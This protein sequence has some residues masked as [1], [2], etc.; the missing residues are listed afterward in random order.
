MDVCTALATC[1]G[2]ARWT[3]LR[4][5]GVSERTLRTGLAS[6]LVTTAGAGGYMLPGTDPALVAAIRLRGVASHASAAR[7]HGLEL[8]RPV[9]GIDVTVRPGSR[10]AGAGVRVHRADL[11]PDE[12]D[13]RLPITSVLRTALDCGRSLPLPDAVVILDSAM[14]GGAVKA[15][16]L[17]VAAEAA[18]GHGAV[19][20]R[21]AVDHADALAGS[22]LESALR[23]LLALVDADVRSQVKIPG[24]GPGPVDFVLDGWLVIEA[25]GFEFHSDRTAY[26]TDRARGN[27][28]AARG[29]TLLRFTWEDVRLRPGWV[30]AQVVRTLRTGP[31]AGDHRGDS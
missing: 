19:A 3:R 18:R 14:R 1:G 21:R 15:A 6:G 22:P 23:L 13:V 7:L 10:P 29:Y 9:S 20:L 11:H 30:L 8:W 28:L 2:A 31:K 17:R 5:L 25:D 16:T 26:R 4:G 12:L 24:V 27:E